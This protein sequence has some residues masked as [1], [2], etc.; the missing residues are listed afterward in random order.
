VVNFNI[1]E[2]IT[3]E[4]SK[5]SKIFRAKRVPLVQKG[6]LFHTPVPFA[7][8]S[9]APAVSMVGWCQDGWKFLFSLGDAEM[10]RKLLRL[11]VLFSQNK[12]QQQN[13]NNQTITDNCQLSQETTFFLWLLWPDKHP[14]STEIK[15][16]VLKN[17]MAVVADFGHWFV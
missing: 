14:Q 1:I 8:F 4:F 5:V 12:N 3:F 17:F 15:K 2:I 16:I 11:G 10:A 13:N 9:A 7:G 6:R